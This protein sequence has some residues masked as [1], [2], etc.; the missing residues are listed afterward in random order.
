MFSFSVMQCIC[1][2]NIETWQS[3]Q[4]A[5]YTRFDDPI[6]VEEVNWPVHKMGLL[7]T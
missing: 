6:I 3:Q 5:L 7:H 4:L 2:S 1:P